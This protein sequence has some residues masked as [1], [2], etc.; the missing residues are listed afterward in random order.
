MYSNLY[1]GMRIEEY[2]LVVQFDVLQDA[3]IRRFDRQIRW[4]IFI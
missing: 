1:I 2:R 3:T 4:Y